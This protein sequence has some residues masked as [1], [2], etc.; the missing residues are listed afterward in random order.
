MNLTKEEVDKLLAEAEYK[1]AKTMPDN[2]HSYTL[3]REHWG[4]GKLELWFAVVKFIWENAVT[5][6]WK[7]GKYYNYYY[8]NGYK[9]W[10]MDATIN[11]TDLI[12]R[13]KL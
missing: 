13:V 6:H 11:K 8:A 4:N 3:M 1:Y 2:P 10:S 12:N 9:Y 7:Y 5:E